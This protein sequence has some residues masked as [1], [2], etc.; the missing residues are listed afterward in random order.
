MTIPADLEYIASQVIGNNES[1]HSTQN[2]IGSTRHPVSQRQI[3]IV[4]NGQDDDS[5]IEDSAIDYAKEK[6]WIHRM[7]SNKKALDTKEDTKDKFY[8]FS[9]V[10]D[11]EDSEDSENEEDQE[12]IKDSDDD[13]DEEEAE[14]AQR[15]L[16]DLISQVSINSS[17]STVSPQVILN[18][19]GL[20][21]IGRIYSLGSTCSSISSIQTVSSVGTV[22]SAS[23]T[24][25][26]A[27]SSTASTVRKEKSTVNAL[28]STLMVIESTVIHKPLL[29]GSLLYDAEGQLIGRVVDTFGP[30]HT[31]FYMVLPSMEHT[32]SG[33]TLRKG[34]PVYWL[35]DAQMVI[36][37]IRSL[38]KKTVDG[39]DDD[40]DSGDEDEEAED[41][42]TERP[43]RRNPTMKQ[44]QQRNRSNEILEEGEIF[45]GIK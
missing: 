29:P 45:W 7:E 36:Q 44:K 6:E 3:V 37:D 19:S 13:W 4:G 12:I 42:E 30:I 14:L 34:M 39:S 27:A 16:A 9:E 22:N 18:Q 43:K 35:E 8:G 31:P 5:E 1:T 32:T 25:S 11:L 23:P 17:S 26:A 33:L 40:A 10:E 24:A 15:D 28:L 20:S 2:H 38:Q 41:S 21:H